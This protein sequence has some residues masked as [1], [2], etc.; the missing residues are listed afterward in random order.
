MGKVFG[1]ESGLLWQKEIYVGRSASK[2]TLKGPGLAIPQN[3]ELP[4]YRSILGCKRIALD[5]ETND[6]NLEAKGP[7]VYRR[8]GFLLGIAI[9]YAD[10]D[11]R[12]YPVAHSTGPNC[13]SE[14]LLQT[15]TKEAREFK[16]IIC[17][18]NIQY[19]LDWLASYGVVFG[20]AQ[21][22]D[23]QYAEPLLDE[24][25]LTY[26]LESI[27]QR[28]LGSGKITSALEQN[29]G[30]DFIKHLKDIHP[31]YVGEYACG[32]VF[33]PLEIM[34]R[35]LVKLEE[36]GLTDLCQME[37]DLIPLLL[38]MRKTGVCV[39][40]K[41][42]DE[43]RLACDQEVKEMMVQM[44][45]LAGIEVQVNSAHTIADAFDALGITYPRTKKGAP[46][47]QRKWL[48]NHPSKLAKMITEIRQIE[49][50]SGTF[51]RNY[52]LGGNTN[53]RVHCMFNPLRGEGGGTV[54]GRFSSS[55]PNLQNIPAR[56][57]KLGP[58]CRRAFI[59]EEDHDWGRIDWSQIEYRFLVHYAVATKCKEA[60]KAAEMYYNDKTTDFHKMA[61]DITH[62]DREIAK[63]INFGIAYGM[64][65]KTMAEN[66]GTTVKEAEPVLNE[67]HTRLPWLKQIYNIASAQ[68]AQNGFIRTILGRKRRF[69]MWEKNK[70]GEDRVYLSDKQ[71]QTMEAKDKR[72]Y[73]RARTHVALNS[74]LQGSAADLMK[75]SMRDAYKAGIFNTLPCHLTVHDELN[76]SI[77][78]NKEGQEAFK[79]LIHIM[80]NSMVL[81]VPILADA[82]IGANWSECK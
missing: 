47:F 31:H 79:E 13:N 53:G 40:V 34:D 32:D 24:N 68:A 50:T 71:Y 57:K 42:A 70:Y 14:V 41:A 8:D 11:R 3:Y 39:D 18:A 45:D 61:A 55:Y 74:L 16:G 52:I 15:L 66:L 77:P 10:G 72:G 58:M 17:G 6:P 48:E 9:D 60:N 75:Q 21:F 49:K 23:V 7:G 27:A 81:N 65:V 78:R 56:H 38:Q 51:L 28:Y 26:D 63:S 22:F 12:Y 73:K 1:D 62:K 80:E 37:H 64:G 20:Q 67:F 59:P 4:S 19:D 5:I 54:S 82:R 2:D 35:Q 30:S 29:Y 69:N 36:E 25:L 46:S 76:C 43:A 44:K 33:L